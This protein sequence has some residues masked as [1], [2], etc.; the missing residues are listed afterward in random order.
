MSDANTAYRLSAQAESRLRKWMRVAHAGERILERGMET[1]D[2]QEIVRGQKVKEN[3]D[4]KA[5]KWSYAF[6]T[7][8]ENALNA[9]AE[10]TVYYQ[11]YEQRGL[12][13]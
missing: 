1:D 13:E 11:E 2:M 5:G 3:A 8:W 9:E 10:S 7:H 6:E 12:H 4:E